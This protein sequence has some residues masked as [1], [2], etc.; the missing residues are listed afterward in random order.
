MPKN[1]AYIK[2]ILCNSLSNYYLR[3]FRDYFKSFQA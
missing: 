1:Q 2:D 3:I